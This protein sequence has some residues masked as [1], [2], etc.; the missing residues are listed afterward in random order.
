[1]LY[2]P[3]F[4]LFPSFSPAKAAIEKNGRNN[5]NI[6]KKRYINE[7]KKD[8]SNSFNK[9]LTSFKFDDFKTKRL[10][11]SNYNINDRK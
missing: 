3:F 9:K 2:H 6:K 1:M 8:D 5:Y 10:K 7:L 11:K 4:A